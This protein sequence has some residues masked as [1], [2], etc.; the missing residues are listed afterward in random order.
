MKTGYIKNKQPCVCN[1]GTCLSFLCTDYKNGVCKGIVRSIYN[2]EGK[3]ISHERPLEFEEDSYK[4]ILTDMVREFHESGYFSSDEIISI[5]KERYGF[6]ITKGLLK[7][8]AT[9]GL[10]NKGQ[11]IRLPK[12]KGTYSIYKKDTPEIINF[13]R[14]AQLSYKNT[15]KKIINYFELLRIKNKEKLDFY[16]NNK[17]L[18]VLADEKPTLRLYPLFWE[19][20]EFQHFAIL[21]ALFELGKLDY[22]NNTNLPHDARV[23]IS[24]ENVTVDLESVFNKKV[25]FTSEG[26][27]IE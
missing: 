6:N 1:S 7:Y 2:K 27:K 10:I 25:I 26:V 5:F 13:V 19:V 21:K 22:K 16:K 14:Y 24:G 4:E 20:A 15:L 3:V 12:V 17:K 23:F 8:Y 18:E 9:E 11:K